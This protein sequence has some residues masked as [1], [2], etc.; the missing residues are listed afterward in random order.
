MIQ[1]QIDCQLN[2]FDKHKQTDDDGDDD[3]EAQTDGHKKV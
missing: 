2:V 3:D 1:K